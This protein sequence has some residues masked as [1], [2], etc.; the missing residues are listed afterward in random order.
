LKAIK[1]QIIIR[2][3]ETETRRDQEIRISEDQDIREL[4]NQDIK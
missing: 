3:G 2:P 4:R 1:G